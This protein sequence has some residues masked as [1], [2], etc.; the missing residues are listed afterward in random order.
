[1]S[2]AIRGRG[3]AFDVRPT[4]SAPGF[5]SGPLFGASGFCKDTMQGACAGILALLGGTHVTATSAPGVIAPGGGFASLGGVLE[6][7]AAGGLTGPIELLG[8]IA[9]FFAAR[10]TIARTLGLL[11][12]I[13]FIVAYVNGYQLPEML[14]AASDLLGRIAGALDA[15]STAGETASAS[16]I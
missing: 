10:R 3:A 8:G 4:E 1:M 12:F 14:S 16:E 13:A 7:L 6:N 11:G 9:L 15:V 2:M 5:L